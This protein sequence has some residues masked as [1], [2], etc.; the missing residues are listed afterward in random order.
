MRFASRR[1]FH[2]EEGEAAHPRGGLTVALVDLAGLR[3]LDDH[4][5]GADD[6]IAGN[7]DVVADGAIHAEKA[8]LA[9][10]AVAGDDHVRRDE[11]MVANR[12]VMANVVAAPQ[13]GVRAEG[14]KGL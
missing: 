1:L 10:V 2:L 8:A 6:A 7:L 5:P 12:G 13:N 9:H 3:V 14:D 11:A 4:G